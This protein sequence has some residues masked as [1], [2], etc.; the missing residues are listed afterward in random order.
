MN[1][2]LICDD[3]SLVREAIAATI[4]RKW[5]EVEI[6]QA[7]DFPTAWALAERA[8]DLCLVD[9]SMPGADGRTGVAGI[10]AAAP[11]ARLLVVT[12]LDDDQLMLDLLDSGVAGFAPKSLETGILAAA[13]DLVLAG[14]RYL[15]ARLTALAAAEP[16]TERRAPA[17]TAFARDPLTPRQ[18]DVLRLMAEGQSNKEIARALD[19][20]PAT[21]KTHV[22]QIIAAVGAVNR[23]EAAARARVLGLI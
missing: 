19:L 12:G 18:R 6:L 7:P 10:L 17:P 23:T 13:I 4:R 3:H 9:L 2:C 15:P 21:I 16:R 22:A 20:S 5:P 11:A 1:L 14:G 8:P